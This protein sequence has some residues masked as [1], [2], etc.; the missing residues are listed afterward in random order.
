M[1][2]VKELS[3]EELKEEY[4][5]SKNIVSSK[6]ALQSSLKVLLNGGYG[7]NGAPQFL[8]F[9]VDNAESTTS[10]GQLVN[11]WT[12]KRINTFLNKL[13]G[14][15]IEKPYWIAGDTDSGYFEL[16][17]IVK[18]LGIQN[19]SDDVI[20]D[21]LDEFVRTIL[22]PEIESYTNELCEYLNNIEN[23][24]VWER[25]V[26][27]PYSIFVAKKRYAMLVKDSEGVRYHDPHLKIVGLESKKSSTPEWA[28]PL[29][30]ECYRYC[31]IQD[32]D[33]YNDFISK[34][35]DKVYKLRIDEIALPTKITGVE[36]YQT[37]DYRYIKGT[38]KHV[39]AAINHNRLIH[40]LG[41]K[42]YKEIQSGDSLKYVS[43]KM[44]NPIGEE[45]IGFSS[46]SFPKEFKL[47]EYI[48]Y[49]EAYERGFEKPLKNF[50]AAINWQTE[51]VVG[52]F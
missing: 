4:T 39:K 33:R 46:S 14:N 10:S 27:A 31:L 37:P 34:V 11:L 9:L 45:T 47:N 13:V 16:D 17:D 2:D 1:K 19:E 26:I 21:S 50:V 36:K 30:E 18:T 24:M 40:E 38:P 29:L 8:Y 28:R 51:E 23:K 49:N 22:E 52:L 25:E 32:K 35:K 48:D 12:T 3:V 15:D 20:A 41:L 7:A 42:H 44:P 5:K 43:L 6:N